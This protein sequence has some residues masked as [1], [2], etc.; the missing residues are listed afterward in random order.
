VHVR[1]AGG[2]VLSGVRVA[3]FN[4]N[5]VNKR[6]ANLLAWLER[7]KPDVVCL[8]E[9]KSTRAQFP[10]KQIRAAGYHALVH[11][12]SAWNGVAILSKH[13]EPIETRRQL[14]GYEKDTQARYL[15]AAVRGV[16]V[17]CLYAPNGNPITGPKFVYKLE[18]LEALLAHAQNLYATKHA[19]VLAGDYNIVPTDAD[20]YNPRSWKRN[21]LLQPKPR[22][23][24]KRLLEQG[25]LDAL[26]AKHDEPIF[27]FWD[28][29]RDH[30]KRNA[31]LRL[32]HVLLS[33]VL[34]P[35]LVDAGVDSWV[36]GEEGASD[37]APTWVELDYKADA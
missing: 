35:T 25:W 31:G 37:H 4:I 11:G 3:T 12:Q 18:W 36:R 6:L 33:D 7:E 17:G 34:K 29:F 5:N 16:I 14:P 1:V 24:Y 22:A 19:V 10:A 21:A 20:I 13:G 27:T 9:L 15:E 8:Q 2:S 26:A 28:Y 32:D 23:L 30:W